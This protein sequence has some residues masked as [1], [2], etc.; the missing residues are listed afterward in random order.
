MELIGH[1][2]THMHCTRAYLEA[3]AEG[4]NGGLQLYVSLGGRAMC[5]LAI[6]SAG[7][8]AIEPTTVVPWYSATKPLTAVLV[9]QL[10]QEGL[11]DL[12][13]PLV[14][15]VPE[16][17]SSAVRVADLLT[18]TVPFAGDLH[19][20]QVLFP[21][22]D[23]LDVACRVR[24]RDGVAPGSVAVYT[25][26]VGWH[27]LAEAARSVAG[28]TFPDLVRRRVLDP[29]GMGDTWLGVPPDQLGA[30]AARQAR[31]ERPGRDGP[32]AMPMVHDDRFRRVAVPGMGALGT[33]RDL[34]RLYEALLA[35]EDAPGLGLSAATVERFTS[36]H[37]RHLVDPVYRSDVRWGLGF[38]TD[39]RV[40]GG[41]QCSTR[42]FGHDGRGCCLSFADPD[43]RLVF[44]AVA[45]RVLEPGANQR[46]FRRVIDAVT[47]D[48]GVAGPRRGRHLSTIEEKVL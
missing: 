43:R 28:G 40:V 44:C 22:D 2:A 25:S 30:V 21:W 5:D 46:R 16:F 8:R 39:R 17:G 24:L 6:G 7:A 38:V 12:D 20:G 11:V 34:G 45:T 33:M 23:V 3:S 27:L 48:L 26:F 9:A 32:A 31:M 1:I 41:G 19:P 47:E 36:V 35:P 18:H 42:T 10:H 13:A 14:D 15:H 29:L 4:D 37:R